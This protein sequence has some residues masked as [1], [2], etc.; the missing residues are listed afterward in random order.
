MTTTEQEEGIRLNPRDRLTVSSNPRDYTER[1]VRSTRTVGYRTCRPK[2]DTIN[3]CMHRLANIT[4][5]LLI[6]LRGRAGN[7]A[8]MLGGKLM[9]PHMKRQTIS[10]NF[11]AKRFP[12]MQQLMRIVGVGVP[13]DVQGQGD[14]V[15]AL[16]CGNYSSPSSVDYEVAAHIVNKIRLGRILLVHRRMAESIQ[17]LRISP[18]A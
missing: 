17:G 14:M 5:I 6:T 8:R 1:L 2:S 11:G 12:E 3:E 16:E 13:V 4:S 15:N 18:L 7:A 10:N 9:A